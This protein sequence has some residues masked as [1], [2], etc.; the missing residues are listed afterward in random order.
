MTVNEFIERVESDM[1]TG[2]RAR[3]RLMVLYYLNSGMRAIA[4]R[5]KKPLVKTALSFAGDAVM[6]GG[7]G[8]PVKVLR[9]WK[10]RNG[11]R[12]DMAMLGDENGM[13]DDP[14]VAVSQDSRLFWRV[15]TEEQTDGIFIYT[16]TDSGLAM[17][18]SQTT[19]VD[20]LKL[21]AE[22]VVAPTVAAMSQRIPMEDPIVFG[23]LTFHVKAQLAYD[24]GQLERAVS[25]EQL[26][27]RS[28]ATETTDMRPTRQ[29]LPDTHMLR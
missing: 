14:A 3:L 28:V 27:E 29:N 9:V 25:L 24:L 8:T 22:M 23:A 6:N 15:G 7:G 12:E 13:L 17:V 18:G 21:G 1:T 10:V 16:L 4:L 19:G 20:D 26:F 11:K 5:I 2:G